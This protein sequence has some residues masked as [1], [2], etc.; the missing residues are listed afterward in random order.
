MTNISSPFL[1]KF[2]C[3][4]PKNVTNSTS[5][6]CKKLGKFPDSPLLSKPFFDLITSH[7]MKHHFFSIIIHWSIFKLIIAP[8]NPLSKS[9]CNTEAQKLHKNTYS[10]VFLAIFH[11]SQKKQS[12]KNYTS[13]KWA[14]TTESCISEV[15]YRKKGD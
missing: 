4:I 12:I 3:K 7:D 15:N 13:V 14:R 6:S 8:L 9:L 1:S 5:I 2:H 10:R 11:L